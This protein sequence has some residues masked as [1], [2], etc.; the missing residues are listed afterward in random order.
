VLVVACR[1]T[2]VLMI[3][4]LW[5]S[6]RCRGGWWRPP[7]RRTAP[8]ELR[9]PI[10]RARSGPLREPAGGAGRRFSA[11]LDGIGISGPALPRRPAGRPTVAGAQAAGDP[12][13]GRGARAASGGASKD[14][15]P[16][17]AGH[18][19]P[20]R[21]GRPGPER[22]ITRAPDIQCWHAHPRGPQAEPGGR[23][24]P[25]QRRRQRT[26]L[27]QGTSVGVDPVATQSVL[28]QQPAQPH[29]RWAPSSSSGSRG[30]RNT[31]M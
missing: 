7:H 30:R 26:R 14:L 21:D 9:R 10:E 13:P 28:G 27:G 24:V 29:C 11:E 5:R 1:P 4:R 20:G 3:S 23:P 18:P 25:G 8:G 15:E 31:G 12:A 2:A 17:G 22:R 6:R 16:V 19:P